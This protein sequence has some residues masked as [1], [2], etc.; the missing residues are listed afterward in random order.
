MAASGVTSL[1][2]RSRVSSTCSVELIASKVEAGRYRSAAAFESDA[3]QLLTQGKGPRSIS[4]EQVGTVVS[5]EAGMCCGIHRFTDFRSCQEKSTCLHATFPQPLAPP[6]SF[7]L[8]MPPLSYSS[9]SN[10]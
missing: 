7:V 2:K 8:C 1:G 10:W 4:A 9:R 5:H 6:P 3:R